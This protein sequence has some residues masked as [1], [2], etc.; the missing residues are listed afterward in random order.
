M[1]YLQLV[2][3]CKC[4]RLRIEGVNTPFPYLSELKD[5]FIRYIDV[6]DRVSED[7]YGNAYVADCNDMYINLVEYHTNNLK[8]N[9]FALNNFA[10]S[11]NKQNRILLNFKIDMEQSSVVCYDADK[12]GKYVYLLYWYAENGDVNVVEEEENN[13]YDANSF[14]V[15][16]DYSKVFFADN[17]ELYNKKFVNLMLYAPSASS[18][19]PDSSD[20]ES[21]SSLSASYKTYNNNTSIT[22]TDAKSLFLTLVKDNKKIL[23]SVPLYVFLYADVYN[24]ITLNKIQ[25]DFTLSYITASLSY[26]TNNRRAVM[27][28]CIYSN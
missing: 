21:A 2:E 26:M 8:Y 5:K 9:D 7:E 1:S 25:F 27:F 13:L 10:L 22:E 19:L 12:I 28:N 15:V 23:D 14:E 18:P 24:I 20:S 6:C 16:V 3:H 17:R 4:V 11:K